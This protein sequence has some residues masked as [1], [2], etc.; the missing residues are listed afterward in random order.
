LK[1][2]SLTSWIFIAMA[3]GIV[4]GHFFPEIG[5]QLVPVSNIFIRMI[6][7][8]IAPLL[9]ATLVVGIAGSGSAK[10]MGRIGLKSIIYFEI[11]TTAA[12]FLGLLAVNFVK[13]GVGLSLE[14]VAA[15]PNLPQAKMS[16]VSILEHTFPNSIID[17][18]A[19][20]EVLQMVVFCFLFGTAC[21]MIGAKAEP[22]VKFLQSLADVMFEYTKYV[23]YLAPFG[24]G[25][26]MAATVGSK[27][28]GV[29]VGLGKLVL[30]LYGALIV[31]VVVVLGAVV[32]IARIPVRRFWQYV[33]D[34]YVLAF[35]TASSEAALP[36]ALQNMQ[37]F[38][39]PKHIVAFV[40]PTGYSFNL[41]GTTLYLSLASVFV[42][43]AAGVDMPLSEQIMMMLTLMLT[44]KGVAAVPRASLIILAG[45]LGTFKLPL[46]G[47]ALLLGVD[48]LMDM[49]RTSVNLLGNCLASAV[50]ARWEGHDLTPPTDVEEAAA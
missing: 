15:D 41:D 25:A 3:A 23:M 1:K 7:S 14:K 45:T 39:V 43:Q 16:F 17:S 34:P 2:L 9:F 30:T 36:M 11:V 42:A 50:V 47:I 46:E 12:L 40:L 38:G 8:I 28:I 19:K 13:P 18:M 48:T 37:K 22:V 33:K 21:T 35:S 24:V 6:K 32:V 10:A 5:K 4:F 26:A 27:G 29:L 31:F 49:A 20:G 44:S